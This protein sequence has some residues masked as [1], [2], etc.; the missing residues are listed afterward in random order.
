[1][2]EKTKETIKNTIEQ[3]LEK[4]GFSGQVSLAESQDDENVIC[5][6]T[7]ENDSNFLIGQY[8]ANLQAIQHLARLMVRK[9]LPEKIRFTLDVN[10][11]R[12]QKNQS[13]IEQARAAADEALA[14]RRAIFMKPMSTYERRIVHLELSKNPEV[15]TESTG[16][17]EDRKIVVKPADMID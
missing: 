1:M 9:M 5:N 3:L 4:M 17:G 2:D 12:Q 16:E 7:T 13:I 10:S 14:Q 6:I 15:S 11:Y 8:G